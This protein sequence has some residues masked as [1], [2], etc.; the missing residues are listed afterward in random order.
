MVEDAYAIPRF[1]P[2]E[3]CPK[4][5]KATKD[6]SLAQ[7]STTMMIVYPSLYQT[8]QVIT[9]LSAP[10][11]TDILSGS[12]SV[13]DFLMKPETSYGIVPTFLPT[14][15]VHSFTPLQGYSCITRDGNVLPSIAPVFSNDFVFTQGCILQATLDLGNVTTI[16]QLYFEIIDSINGGNSISLGPEL[17][18][19][20][21]PIVFTSQ[22]LTKIVQNPIF[23]IR[24]STETECIR[25]PSVTIT[26]TAGVLAYNRTILTQSYDLID[27]IGSSSLAAQVS[28]SDRISYTMMSCHIANTTADVAIGGTIVATQCPAGYQN[29]LSTNPSAAFTQLSSINRRKVQMNN[30][31]DGGWWSYIPEEIQQLEFRNAGSDILFTRLGNYQRP[32][33]VCAIKA[34]GLATT[35]ITMK[36][37]LGYELISADPSL[38]YTI[39]PVSRRDFLMLFYAYF[40]SITTVSENPQHIR[41]AMSWIMGAL[42]RYP[43]I[44]EAAKLTFQAGKVLVPI[45]LSLL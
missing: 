34:P 43:E 1:V 16:D 28:N 35:S 29:Q 4:V 18:R 26:Y 2:T 6:I 19:A 37:N 5:S 42:E 9:P 31:K 38:Q 12:W 33:Y 24:G 27:L 17:G 23:V 36:L 39:S 30:F 45:A 40:N 14:S 32:F 15:P 7:D 44:T 11:P 25:I 41:N 10:I 21:E 13:P 20:N 3:V 8:L 22:A